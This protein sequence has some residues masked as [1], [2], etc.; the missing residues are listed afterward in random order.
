[1][2]DRNHDACLVRRAR[3]KKLVEDVV[4]CNRVDHQ[5]L[6]GGICLRQERVLEGI[7]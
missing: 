3:F 5:G 7:I 4:L 6:A 1:M 2:D